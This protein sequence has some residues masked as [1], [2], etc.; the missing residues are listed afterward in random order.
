MIEIIR[1]DTLPLRFQRK[2]KAGEV[3]YDLPEKAY[4]SVKKNFK[5]DETL[6]QKTL[7]DMQV[8]SEGYYHFI[9]EPADTD[10]LKYDTYVYDVEVVT[11]GYKQTIARGDFIVTEEVTFVDNEV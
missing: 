10:G 6:I 1:G 8:D 4:F 11:A 7:A 2:N 5:T 3:I 9:V